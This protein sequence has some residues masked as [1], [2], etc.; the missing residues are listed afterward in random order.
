VTVT[1][2]VGFT[3]SNLGSSLNGEKNNFKSGLQINNV[4]TIT[5]RVLP[6]TG[7]H[8]L[9][10]PNIIIDLTNNEDNADETTV[11]STNQE[12]NAAETTVDSTNQEDNSL[13]KKWVNF[14]N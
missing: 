8:F 13:P 10:K 9:Y 7:F 1:P 3:T 6:G 5:S 11:V 12:D 2:D 14:M 4:S